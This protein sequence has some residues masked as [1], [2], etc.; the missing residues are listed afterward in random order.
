MSNKNYL[1]I[2]DETLEEFF[3]SMMMPENLVKTLE[4]IVN[5]KFDLQEKVYSAKERYK[6]ISWE[7]MEKKYLNIL[8]YL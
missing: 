4:D 7:E 3:I 1:D 2:S 6:N 8:R 5:G